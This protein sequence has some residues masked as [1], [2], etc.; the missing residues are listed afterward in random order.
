M[1]TK[2]L[3]RGKSGPG[4][5]ID[6]HLS[7]GEEIPKEFLVRT[8]VVFDGNLHPVLSHILARWIAL[9]AKGN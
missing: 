3:T 5:E 4:R 2:V 9:R 1:I 6:L 8:W 7:P